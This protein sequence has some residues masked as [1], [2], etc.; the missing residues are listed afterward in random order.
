MGDHPVDDQGLV[1]P[2]ASWP[3]GREAT[4][5]LERVRRFL[6]STNLESGADRLRTPTTAR[7]WLTVEGHACPARLTGADVEGLRTV[8]ELVRDIVSP[9]EERAA[10]AAARLDRLLATLRFR[11]CAAPTVHVEPLGPGLDRF[12]GWLL[13]TMHEATIDGRWKR[14][15]SCANPHCRWVAFDH[16][17]NAAGTWCSTQACGARTK[18]RSYRSRRKASRP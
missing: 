12:L 8:R 9:G 16:S 10:A 2:D 4:G 3:P 7:V 18:A 1:L 5:D 15:T 11:V 17:R 14:M 6:N 13:V